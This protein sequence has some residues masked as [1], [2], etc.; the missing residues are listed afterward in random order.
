MKLDIV[1]PKVR[2]RRGMSSKGVVLLTGAMT[3]SWVPPP[4]KTFRRNT[5]SIMKELI[6]FKF[7][8]LRSLVR[9]VLQH[10]MRQTAV[11][12]S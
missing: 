8:T 3:R 2:H 9:S 12:V 11:E 7:S 10:L 6:G 5:A 1:L 4:R